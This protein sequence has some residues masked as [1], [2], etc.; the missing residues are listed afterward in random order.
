MNHCEI[1]GRA[2]WVEVELQ[3]ERMA[4]SIYSTHVCHEFFTKVRKK[5]KSTSKN[6]FSALEWKSIRL[7]RKLVTLCSIVLHKTL[8]S[9]LHS[10]TALKDYY[11]LL[12]WW[13]VCFL[14][15]HSVVNS[16]QKSYWRK[17]SKFSTILFINA[18]HLI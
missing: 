16:H 6:D 5:N 12:Q 8:R 7:F 14:L 11:C 18:A 10:F 13:S 15:H 4:E 2:M 1:R 9:L 17:H 3:N